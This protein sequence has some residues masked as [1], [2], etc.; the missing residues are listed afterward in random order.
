[1]QFLLRS[2]L[3]VAIVAIVA[4]VAVG[5]AGYAR[6]QFFFDNQLNGKKAPNFALGSIQGKKVSLDETIKGKKAILFFW[7]TWCPHCSEQI[8]ELS[9]HKAE[10]EKQGVVVLLID[11]GEPANPVRRFAAYRRLEYDVLLD[12][13]GSVSETYQ[14]VGI[15]T[16]VFIGTDGIVRESL[17]MF[18]RKYMELLK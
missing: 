2:M 17:H 4:G 6:G 3:C 14:V 5:Y 13:E 7:A 8:Q 10:L 18:P 1:M 9:S 11:T 15:P 16:L 12:T